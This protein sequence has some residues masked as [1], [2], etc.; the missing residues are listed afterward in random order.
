MNAVHSLYVV[1]SIIPL[2]VRIGLTMTDTE[3]L[4]EPIQ[5]YGSRIELIRT[6]LYVSAIASNNFFRVLSNS[7]MATCAISSDVGIFL[8]LVDVFFS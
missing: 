8:L 3:N 1:S 6:H 7:S 2:S 4:N 5:G